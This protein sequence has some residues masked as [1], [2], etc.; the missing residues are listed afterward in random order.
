M[1]SSGSSG[2]L[3]GLAQGV[4]ARDPDAAAASARSSRRSSRS[5]RRSTVSRPCRAAARAAVMPAPPAPTTT[6]S[7]SSGSGGC[8]WRKTVT[9]SI[10]GRHA[11][12]RRT[13]HGRRRPRGRRAGPRADPAAARDLARASTSSTPTRSSCSTSGGA[14]RPGRRV[15]GH[16]VGLSSKAMQEMMGVDEPDYG[17]LLS[18]MEVSDGRAGRRRRAT[19]TRASRSRSAFVLGETLPGEGCTEDDVLAGDRD[20]APAI[21][22]IDSRIVDWNIRIADTIADNASSAGLRARPG[23]GQARATSTCRPST[24]VLVTQR[25]EGRRGPLRR[26]ARQPGHRRGLAGR[27]GGVVRGHPR[28]RAR[29]PARLGAPRDRR[30][31]RRRLRRRLRRPRHRPTCPSRTERRRT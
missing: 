9:G 13:T 4:V 22:L 18:D 21:E 24:R 28:G 2:R 3:A 6:T 16:K 25:R 17:H 12:R 30:T 20:V 15:H 14:S 29:D 8:S 7:T 19:A 31:P 5:S 23:A 27:Q 11:L 26:R 10:V 1:D